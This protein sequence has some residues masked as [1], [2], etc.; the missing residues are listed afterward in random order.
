[1]LQGPLGLVLPIAAEASGWATLPW[2][3]GLQASAEESTWPFAQHFSNLY[4]PGEHAD[5][6]SSE[7]FGVR[8]S[9]HLCS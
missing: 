6:Y 3:Q 4:G 1:M 5:V 2:S 8:P 7:H 9:W